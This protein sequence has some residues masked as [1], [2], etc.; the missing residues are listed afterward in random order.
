M[1]TIQSLN[2]T[3]QKTS[4]KPPTLGIIGGGQLAKMTAQAAFQLGGEVVVLE[5]QEDFP[6]NSLDTHMLV[7]DWDD[8]DDLL[9]LAARAGV[10]TLEN[11]FVDAESL[12]V[13][14]REG[15]K[16]LPRAETIRLVQDKLWQKQALRQAG[17]PVP[18]FSD[19]PSL[20]EAR[21]AAGM[22]GWPLLLKKRRNGYD[23]KGNATVSSTVELRQ[24]WKR[25][26]G[27]ANAL[28]VEK[29]CP[30]VK[31]LA[32][33][34][35]RGQDG[36][37][38]AY[39]VVET[40]QHNHICHI[41][42]APAS[43]S[44]EIAERASEIA[45]RAVSAIDGV[46]SMGVEFFLTAYDEL[47]V[48]EMAPRVHNSGHYTI[49]ACVCSQFENHVRAVLGW[50][51]GSTAMRAPAAVMINLLGV[52]EG[53]G[54]PQGL[55]EALQVEGAHVHIYGKTRSAPGR[56]MGHVTALASTAEEALAMAQRAADRIR[57]G[58]ER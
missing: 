11:E 21:V 58:A 40:I 26:D 54:A 31:E 32:V 23:G 55:P 2:T 18:D 24:A 9:R 41:V 37:E 49:E 46:G 43:I 5:R 39:P 3:A 17:L 22:F 35:T 7:G 19:A 56:K 13:V 36:A 48:N 28:Y 15:Y 6:A 33:M 10:I 57:F 34:I 16:L 47:F 29:F 8:P 42:L 14:E 4:H 45:R 50:P 52:G 1:T 44:S 20:E 30:F 51:L 27:E 53:A 12:A 38:A 25:L